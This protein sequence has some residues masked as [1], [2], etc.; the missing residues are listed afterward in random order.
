M[1]AYA[2]WQGAVELTVRASDGAGTTAEPQA[3]LA[4]A[5]TRLGLGIDASGPDPVATPTHAGAHLPTVAPAGGP[6]GCPPL[7][8]GV[9]PVD[10]HDDVP[11]E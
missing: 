10:L 7:L 3:R 9:D 8:D 5:P 1:K 11:S 6:S 2:G 4:A